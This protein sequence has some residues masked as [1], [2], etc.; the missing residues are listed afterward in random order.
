M[1]TAQAEDLNQ[2]KSR[3]WK[4]PKHTHSNLQ[5]EVTRKQTT[6][7]KAIRN[8][9]VY[10]YS[11]ALKWPLHVTLSNPP[12]NHVLKCH[13]TLQNFIQ[14]EWENIFIGSWPNSSYTVV[15]PIQVYPQRLTILSLV[16]PR[17][18]RSKQAHSQHACPPQH[19]GGSANNTE[20]SMG[21]KRP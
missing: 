10:E 20:V 21:W 11:K 14:I 6:V 3:N 15:S 9:Q 18:L 7:T 1:V 4:K 17:F 19:L 13:V 16:T 12:L 8:S 2:Y 5:L